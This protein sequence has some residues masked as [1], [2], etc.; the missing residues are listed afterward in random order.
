MACGT[1]SPCT[2][3][4]E[5]MHDALDQKDTP[6]GLRVLPIIGRAVRTTHSTCWCS[7]VSTWGLALT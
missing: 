7:R 1:S 5:D 6:G 4:A 3:F 2:V